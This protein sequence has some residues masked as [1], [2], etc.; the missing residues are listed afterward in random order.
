MISLLL[1]VLLSI[2]ADAYAI[3]SDISIVSVQYPLYSQPIIQKNYTMVEPNVIESA[4]WI[5]TNG[6]TR[7]A[8]FEVVFYA[9]FSTSATLHLKANNTFYAYLNGV[10]IRAGTKYETTAINILTACGLNNL[11]I[12]VENKDPIAI[13]SGL[14]FAIYQAENYNCGTN[15]YYNPDTCACDCLGY[16]SCLPNQQI[17][18]HPTCA[19][20]CTNQGITRCNGYNQY[21]DT[22]TC[23]CKCFPSY[24]QP[25]FIFDQST[26]SCRCKPTTCSNGAVWNYNQCR[27]L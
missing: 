24:C 11:T 19:C 7:S 23:A 10:I 5:W 25:G 2:S 3:Y 6:T 26:C 27:C 13:S 12:Q 18:G 17:L 9:R 15:G 22:K 8:T 21:F 14:V 4:N 1:L 20:A 16:F